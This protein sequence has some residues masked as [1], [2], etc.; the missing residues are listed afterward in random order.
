MGELFWVT[1]SQTQGVFKQS[2]L[3]TSYDQAY[4]FVELF[5]G[6]GLTTTAL[7]GSGTPSAALD[8][9]YH[10]ATQGKQNYMDLLTP[11]GFA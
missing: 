8:I 4:E 9:E 3:S 2:D 10:Q 5:A 11:A 7:K 6:K 1:T